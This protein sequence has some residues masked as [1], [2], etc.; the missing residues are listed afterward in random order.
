MGL[1]LTEGIYFAK[2]D[3][4]QRVPRIVVSTSIGVLLCNY[5]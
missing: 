2:G 1:R 4:W 5:N 3:S